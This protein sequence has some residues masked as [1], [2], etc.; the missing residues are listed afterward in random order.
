MKIPRNYIKSR[1]ATISK[2]IQEK[3]KEIKKL[4]KLVVILRHQ[5]NI[6]P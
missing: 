2:S 4:E 3:D 5:I 6:D 1:I